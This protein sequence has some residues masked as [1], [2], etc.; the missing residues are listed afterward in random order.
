MQSSS[1]LF[2]YGAFLICCGFASVVFIGK[3]AKTALISG[4]ISG[5]LALGIAYAVRTAISGAQIL[6]MVLAF[7]LFLVFSWRSTK[8][9]YKIFELL[10]KGENELK[11]K[12]IAFLIISLM[13]LV[14]IFV[15]TLQIILF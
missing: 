12:G 14:S 15:L 11:G 8:T 13:A 4:G 5:I 6:G 2:F 10:P 7:G 9:L 3:K 1:V